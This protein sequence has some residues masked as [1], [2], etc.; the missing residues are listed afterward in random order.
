MTDPYPRRPGPLLLLLAL[1]A[2]VLAGSVVGL[3]VR[4]GASTFTAT[5]LVSVDE[6]RAVAAAGDAGILEKLSRIRLRYTGLVPTDLLA[7]PVAA[8]L[9]V[10]VG[11]VRGRL[12]ATALPQDLLLRLACVE[13]D[14]A[15]ARRCAD[16]LAASL[17][18]LVAHEQQA[19]GI[20]ADQQ[21]VMTQVQPAGPPARTGPRRSRTA[22]L[23]LLG[24]LLA[25]GLVLA[26]GTRLRR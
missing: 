8:R 11:Q 13:P 25:A 2:A 20:P 1:V 21:L 7:A 10:P 3:A 5:A 9:G 6:P 19:G 26:A 14:A 16:A 17:V 22:A 15:P 24:G 18:D 12:S 23:A 4:G